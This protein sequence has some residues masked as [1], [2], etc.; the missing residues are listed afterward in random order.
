MDYEVT[1]VQSCSEYFSIV[2]LTGVPTPLLL[3]ALCNS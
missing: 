1:N 2:E 3:N